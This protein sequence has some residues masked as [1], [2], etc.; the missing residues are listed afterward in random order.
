[1]G[2]ECAVHRHREW[3][4]LEIHHVWPMGDG[5]PNS[6]ANKV[7]VCEN[8]HGAIHAYIDHLRRNPKPP[9]V[10]RR[11]FGRKVRALGQLGFDRITRKAM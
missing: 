11:R 6:P 1:M 8:G 7:T 5:G 2:T 4:P 9:W 3:V 10:I